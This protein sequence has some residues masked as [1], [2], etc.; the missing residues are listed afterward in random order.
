[1]FTAGT[2]PAFLSSV[3]T[4]GAR[5]LDVSLYKVFPM[6]AER[7]LRFE[8]SS[9]NVTNTEQFGYPNIF[10]NPQEQ[11]DSTVMAGFGQITNSANTPRQF[12]F[13]SRFTF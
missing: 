6:G 3:R 7:N 1:M 2:A 11:F 10:W 9:Y 4:A 12:Q 8:I 13:G 5:D